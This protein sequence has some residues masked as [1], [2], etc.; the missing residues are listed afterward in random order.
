MF[1]FGFG[2]LLLLGVIALVVLGP[3]RLPVAARLLGRWIRG[4]R[5]QWNSVKAELENEIADEELRR[6]LREAAD[7]LRQGGEQMRQAHAGLAD[8]TGQMTRAVAAPAAGRPT[9]P[10]GAALSF[11]A[12][13]DNPV[14][15]T[16]TSTMHVQG[17][18]TLESSA[19]DPLQLSLLD[20]GPTTSEHRPRHDG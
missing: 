15:G 14:A 12:D 6:N 7:A 2:E 20:A 19:G 9:D 10:A 16:P 17:P 1:D 13:A 18:A 8:A 3:E 5:N 11:F 4:A